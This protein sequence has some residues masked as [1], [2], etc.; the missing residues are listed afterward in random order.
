MWTDDLSDLSD[1]LDNAADTVLLARRCNV[2]AIL[3][4]ALYELVVTEGL[5][6]WEADQSDPDVE[7]GENKSVLSASD[8]LVDRASGGTPAS[9]R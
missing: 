6:Q 4:R 3:K 5:K 8:F 1:S 2:N 9:H 7:D